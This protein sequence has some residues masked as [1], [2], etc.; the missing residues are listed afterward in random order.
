ML[1]K[2]MKHF[3]QL[4]KKFR[5]ISMILEIAMPVLFSHTIPTTYIAIYLYFS[6]FFLMSHHLGTIP[7]PLIVFKA[8][9][10]SFFTVIFPTLKI[11]GSHFNVKRI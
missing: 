1:S 3:E 4:K 2:N 11:F 9:R 8:L 5:K 7:L 6:P 10:I